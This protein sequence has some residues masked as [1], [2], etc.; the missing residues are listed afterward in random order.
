MLETIDYLLMQCSGYFAQ[1]H[2]GVICRQ[3][4]GIGKIRTAVSADGV[5]K[6][7]GRNYLKY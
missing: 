2:H 7:S 5:T 1:V 3:I 4:M 6:G